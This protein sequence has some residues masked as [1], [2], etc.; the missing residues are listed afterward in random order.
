MLKHY[1]RIL[2]SWPVDK[3]RPEVSFQKALQRRIDTRLKETDSAR[4]LQNNI[5]ANEA[6]V[7]VPTPKPFD[8]K[9]ELEQVNA[10][11]SL[12]E[13]RYTKKVLYIAFNGLKMTQA[14]MCTVSP[15]R[16]NAET[17]LKSRPLHKSSEGI[18]RGAKADVACIEDQ[19]LERF[20]ASLMKY[21]KTRNL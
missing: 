19:F 18:G 10:L 2:T 9:G 14:D 13:N 12:L 7:T 21:R 17:I 1:Q 20:L 8:E 6:Q 4:S 11:Y 15:L 5:V 16:T 3:L